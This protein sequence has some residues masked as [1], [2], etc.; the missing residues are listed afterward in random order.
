MRQEPE[1]ARGVLHLQSGSRE[2]EMWCAAPILLI[3][4]LDPQ[5]MQRVFYSW[6]WAGLPTSVNVIHKQIQFWV[7]SS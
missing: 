7:L 2:T 1:K 4:S 5:S 6:R 3:V